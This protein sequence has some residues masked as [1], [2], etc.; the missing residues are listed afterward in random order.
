[1]ELHAR[2]LGAAKDLQITGFVLEPKVAA[3]WIA[4]AAD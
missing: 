1:V 3:E 2:V 4:A